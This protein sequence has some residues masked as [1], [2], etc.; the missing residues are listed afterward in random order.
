M[1]TL[2]EQKQVVSD[3][4]LFQRVMEVIDEMGEYSVFYYSIILI[5]RKKWIIF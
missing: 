5:N 3:N 4:S 1:R 2:Q